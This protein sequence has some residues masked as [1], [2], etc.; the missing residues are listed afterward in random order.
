MK[1]LTEDLFDEN[2]LDI[3][4]DK[5]I[6]K[7]VKKYK[8]VVSGLI[9][10][11]RYLKDDDAVL[12]ISKFVGR[13]ELGAREI[14]LDL[15]NIARYLEDKDTVLEI[16]R[17]LKK[18]GNY[19]VATVTHELAKI[20]ETLRDKDVVLEISKFVGRY[21]N[22]AVENVILEIGNIVDYLKD[23]DVILKI[24]KT[25]E[26]YENDDAEEI[27][28]KLNTIVA[29]DLKDK[30]KILRIVDMFNKIGKS[31]FE[32]LSIK[33]LY[34]IIDSKLDELIKDKKSF[35]FVAAY[36]KSREYGETLPIPNEK[37]IR[38]YDKIVLDYLKRNY[39][40]KKNI[41]IDQALMLFSLNRNEI[42]N[43]VNLVNNSKEI[44]PRFYSIE[45]DDEKDLEH[46]DNLIEY[47]VISIIGSR[48]RNKEIKAVNEIKKIV[49]EKAIYRARNEFNT[50]FKSLKNE[51]FANFRNLEY[52]DALEKTY[53]MLKKTGNEVINDVL[54]ATRFKDEKIS[55]K[56]IKAVESKNP[57]DYNSKEQIA[58]VY[59]PKGKD[60]I[61]YCEDP[62]I[63]LVKYSIGKR[64]LGS[65]ICYFEKNKFLVDSFEAHRK[66]R[67]DKIYEIVFIDSKERAKIRGADIVI[68][69]K[70]VE[71]E[72]PKGFVNY[73]K[74][75]NLKEGRVKMEL[76]TNSFLE[77]K[78]YNRVNGYI[79]NLKDEANKKQTKRN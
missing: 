26:K 52:R 70:N 3:L 75:K 14:A 50:K 2:S 53:F 4:S 18:Y 24:V 19:A 45:S 13:Y 37:N 54:N 63:V 69:N 12:E 43:V 16:S 39:D 34:N 65:T 30:Q 40:I 46:D 62:N 22:W 55:S 10:I 49:G 58:C 57:L 23:K 5:R 60:I 61:D 25:V 56:V 11:A 76:N 38:N 66:L 7:T 36:I 32:D 29:D 44:N 17:I 42:K 6:L 35:G 15:G 72:T 74:R 8:D 48:D 64:T 78:A 20:T 9:N 47:A 31:I 79:V 28:D 67:K 51:I 33:E 27:I 1:D 41:G 77:A 21:E 71:N 68:F 73:L 59:L